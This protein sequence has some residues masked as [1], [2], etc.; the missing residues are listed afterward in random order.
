M[1]EWSAPKPKTKLEKFLEQPHQ[2]FFISAILTAILAFAFSILSYS[3]V[4]GDFINCHTFTLMYG[5]FANAFLGFLMTVIP[6]YTQSS[7]IKQ[8]FYVTTWIVFE[9]GILISFA[10]FEIG[11]LLVA[12]ALFG[13]SAIFAN[14][15]L[16]GRV[17]NQKESIW[18][19]FHIFAGAL[20]LILH[21]FFDIALGFSSLWFFVLPL[22]FTIAQRMIFAF[23]RVYHNIEQSEISPIFLAFFNILFW[24]IGICFATNT[25]PAL[26]A[27]ILLIATIYLLARSPIYKKSPPILMIL[28]IGFSWLPIGIF[29][30]ILESLLGFE[31]LKLSTH[32]LTVGFGLTLLIGFG[33]RVILGHSG[34][35]IE[36]DKLANIIFIATQFV[37]IFRIFVSLSTFFVSNFTPLI[38]INLTLL[39][40][41]FVVWGAKYAK[42]L[43]WR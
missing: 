12:T 13:A 7:L 39:G 18:V 35:K 11:K 38:H 43:A 21:Y 31:A 34:Q 26:F 20:V 15:I 22:F 16:K 27:I 36:T 1:F 3:G 37:V 40:L 4:F 9:A 24:T 42:V 2:L 41:I 25:N 28:T 6:R 23:H 30:L 10:S 19:T 33:T 8:T 5:V 14:T 32:I 29:V 17:K